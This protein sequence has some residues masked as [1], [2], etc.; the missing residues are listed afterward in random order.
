MQQ[1]VRSGWGWSRLGG[2][3][4]MGTL[5]GAVPAAAQSATIR[6]A[7][8][9][10]VRG[11][12]YANTNFG[13]QGILETR[14]SSNYSYVR[15][16]VLTF[17]TEKTVPDNAS[18]QSARLM[19]TV[20]SGNSATRRL[21]ARSI[22]ISFDEPAV[23]WKRR[24]SGIA[25]KNPGVD[26]TGT[27]STA[28][29]TSTPRSRV[30]FD[31]TKQVQHVING[32]YGT[33]YARFVVSDL[34]T[35][36]RASYKQYFSR[37]A[38]DASLRPTLVVNWGASESGST[39]TG[40][41]D[42][43]VVLPAVTYGTVRAGSYANKFQGDLLAT[44]ASS[45]KDY[46]RRA[47]LKFDTQNKI[48]AGAHILSAKMTVYVTYANAGAARHVAAYQVRTSN[49][50]HDFSWNYRYISQG[51]RWGTPGG[52]LG[53]KLAVAT[54]GSTKGAAVTYDVTSLVAQAVSGKLGS[55]YTRIALIDLDGSSRDSYREYG[56]PKNANTSLRPK[57]TVSYT[58]GT[59]PS[60][61]DTGGDTSGGSTSSA[62]RF[63]QW[64]VHHGG[65]G[66]DGRYDPA[67]IASWVAKMKPDII[68]FNEVDNSTQ[69]SALAKAVNSATGR[70]WKTAYSGLGNLLLTRWSIDSSSICVTNSSKNR[71]APHMSLVVNGRRINVWSTHLSVDSASERMS[72]AKAMT[73]CEQNWSEAR[74]VGGDFNMQSSSTEYNYMANYNIDGWAKAASLGTATH[75]MSCNGCT[76]NSRIDYIFSSKGATFLSVASARVY[77]TRNSSGV[78]PSD[79]KPLVVVYNVK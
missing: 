14:Q 37:E 35:S 40:S 11:G 60:S 22:P 8:D 75:Y 52:D 20:K 23:T 44:R 76:R 61:E 71:K 10:T 21:T 49:G 2:V 19:L 46:L 67:R 74:I 45:T 73:A 30:A 50:D 3:L 7:K 28:T 32:D 5:L 34:G 51:T 68:S 79:H 29:V 41:A 59:A 77:D 63:L 6:V 42:P 4:M 78:M 56:T 64:N 16:A 25:W 70:T 24:K 31:V 33:R 36:S 65:V 48:P 27:A 1:L 15:R 57:L 26:V 66:T 18:I 43:T 9:A 47:M 54:V 13:R 72:E 53:T 38:S 12:S 55:R 62:I 58:T 17:D 39:N 69:A